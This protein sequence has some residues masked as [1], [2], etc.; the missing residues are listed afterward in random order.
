MEK[1][2]VSVV[3][4]IRN[5]ENRI[6]D[7]LNKV[8]PEIKKN[9]QQYEIVCVDDGSEDATVLQIKDYVENNSMQGIVSIVHMGFPQGVEA[10]MNAGRDV[11][12]GDF[13]YEFDTVLVDYDTK[14]VFEVYEKML[15]GFD[16]VS[17]SIE[18]SSSFS[19]KS[20]Y[21]VFNNNSKSHNDISTESFRIISRRAINRI[22]SMGVYIPYRKAVCSNC[23][24]QTSTIGYK[25]NMSTAARRKA[26]GDKARFSDRSKLAFDS[27]IYFTNIM[28]KISATISF[29]FLLFSVG[30]TVYTIC[31]YFT[32][33]H[34]AEGWASLMCVISIG[35]FGVFMLLTI[36]LK[37]LSVTLNLIF[38]KT[39][40][41]VADIEKIVG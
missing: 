31:D 12:I 39:K 1:K 20:F 5:D 41:L 11:S 25:S 28:E 19:S 2:F 23:G 32:A 10:A 7:F 40:Y 16:I 34:L 22:K 18:N 35:F 38:K 14:L 29:I 6:V 3:A 4:Y 30:I 24:L 27:F 9:F 15:S 26:L 33:G 37:Y 36:V 17:A 21:K 8:V 13:V